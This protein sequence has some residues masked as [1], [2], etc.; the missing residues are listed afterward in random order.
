M[1]RMIS[2]S[3]A[4]HDGHDAVFRGLEG[5][6]AEIEPQAGLAGLGVEAVAMEARIRHDGTDIA[7]EGELRFGGPGKRGGQQG[8]GGKQ[9][10]QQGGHAVEERV[11]EGD[12][13]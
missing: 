4:G 9:A 2:L 10:A 6:V 8:G 7:V 12:P 5:V 13:G 1:R 3:F 11:A